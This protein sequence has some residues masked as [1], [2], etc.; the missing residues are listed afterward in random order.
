MSKWEYAEIQVVSTLT[1]TH[2]EAT[3]FK[4]DGKHTKRNEKLGALL[5][6]LGE[7]GWEL[8]SAGHRGDTGSGNS[9]KMNYVL[10]RPK[11]TAS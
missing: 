5:A 8:V 1:G 3:F 9:N 11:E 4:P 10:K 7:D 2:G 6:Q